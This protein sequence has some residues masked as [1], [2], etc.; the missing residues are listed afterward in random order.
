MKPIKPF[1]LLAIL[2]FSIN[3][4]SQFDPSY[5]SRTY[6]YV[7][8]V[9]D[10]GLTCGSCWSF[11]SC[12]AIESSFLKQ[13]YGTFDL[14]EDNLTD[15]HNFDPGPCE[16]GNYYM[17]HAIL[18]AH[19]GVLTE[20]QDPYTTS[21]QDCPFNQIFPPEP[22]AF[23]EEM[24]IIS[25]E[26]D[27]IKQAILDYGAVASSMFFNGIPA[28][29]DA[30]NYKYYDAVIGS[31][32]EPY[33]HCVTIVGWDDN[34]TFTG[35]PD[36]GGWIIKDSY[37]TSWANS[38]YFYCS[39]YDAGILSSNVVFPS[40]EEIPPAVN[41][42]HVYYYDEFGWVNNYG[43]TSNEAYAL[44]K[45]TIMPE[46]GNM[47][48]Q[49]IKRIGTYAV[50]ENCT[51]DLELYRT[52]TGNA[53][54]D[55]ITSTSINCDEA[56]FY[57]APLNLSTDTIGSE[58]FIK[59]KYTCDISSNQ[60]I[61]IEEY[62]EYS[63]SAFTSTTGLCWISNDG[64]NWTQIGGGTSYDFDLCIKMYT[65]NGPKAIMSDIPESVCINEP[66]NLNCENFTFDSIKWYV[67]DLQ[68]SD[69]PNY[70]YFPTESGIITIDLIVW[71]GHNSDTVTKSL[72]V[73][74][75]P[76]QP[77]ISQ[78]SEHLESSSAFAYQW[79]SDGL[80]EL[81]GETNQTFYPISNGNYI[82]RVFNEW[83]C[84]IDSEPFEFIV[85][86]ITQNQNNSF[87]VYPNPANDKLNIYSNNKSGK[88]KYIKIYDSLGRLVYE[89]ETTK[90]KINLD[91]TDFPKGNYKIQLIEGTD[92]TEGSFIKN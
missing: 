79:H 52:K 5:D 89:L 69:M 72:T 27:D 26:I 29:Y 81:V 32:D 33:A 10:Q 78:V 82:V 53:L 14:S 57:T 38:G 59:V 7:T 40:V 58:I 17:T 44:I 35:A 63:Y 73:Y 22:T 56:G 15:C 8:P 50:T 67:N 11:A 12:A 54:S 30:A 21:T 60:P 85:E 55:F 70:T 9:K 84:F 66:V 43:Y 48:G 46:S 88:N 34:I 45:Y 68:V 86:N 80:V 90:D 91:L 75:L 64:S 71:S 76:E 41:V 25:N 1:L 19:H 3:S 77:V 24:R 61:P 87:T 83:G 42:P 6:G 28:N 4:F 51:I 47:S 23:V 39:Y 31:E 65:E 62:E 16:W 36:N 18:S 13:G 92:R 49:Q 20:T 2:F 37:G 74:E